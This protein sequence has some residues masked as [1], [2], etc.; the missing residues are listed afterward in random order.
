MTS[1]S[2]TEL[3]QLQT[4]QYSEL[5]LAGVEDAAEAENTSP[6]AQQRRK[7]SLLRSGRIP[8]PLFSSSRL[9]CDWSHPLTGGVRFPPLRR[10]QGLLEKLLEQLPCAEVDKKARDTL[11]KVQ[12]KLAAPDY[13]SSW[14]ESGFLNVQVRRL[15]SLARLRHPLPRLDPRSRPP[16]PSPC[17]HDFPLAACRDGAQVFRFTNNSGYSSSRNFIKDGR[18]PHEL[19][20]A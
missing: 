11:G 4:C 13:S 9:H 1:S 18:R 7:D 6:Q 19:R 16:P 3:R 8:W 20:T 12:S 5:L 17:A 14:S 15:L 10:A 2:S